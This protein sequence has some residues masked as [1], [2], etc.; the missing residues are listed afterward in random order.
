MI[1]PESQ[2]TKNHGQQYHQSFQYK[3]GSKYHIPTPIYHFF[4]SQS[5]DSKEEDQYQYP[6][7]PN[8]T[9]KSH[10]VREYI[11]I[12]GKEDDSNN[13]KKNEIEGNETAPP[14]KIGYASNTHHAEDEE[15]S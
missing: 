9:I 1:K 5:Q 10:I 7:G 14:G 4:Q 8:N 6:H 12:A 3:Q 13:P 11:L 2:N 15:G